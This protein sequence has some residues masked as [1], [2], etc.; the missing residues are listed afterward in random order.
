MPQVAVA[1]SVRTIPLPPSRQTIAVFLISQ[2]NSPH[3][4]GL[5]LYHLVFSE[6]HAVSFLII[7]HALAFR[8]AQLHWCCNIFVAQTTVIRSHSNMLAPP[9]FTLFTRLPCFLRFSLLGHPFNAYRR[10]GRVEY[11][12]KPIAL[13]SLI[14]LL[15]PCSLVILRSCVSLYFIYSFTLFVN[16]FVRPSSLSFV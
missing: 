15:L 13:H 1:S 7:S 2:P 10:A 11:H 14:F 9:V 8:L 6:A 4:M 12:R 5:S 16:A 3:S